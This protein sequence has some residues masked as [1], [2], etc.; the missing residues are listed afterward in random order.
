MK[1]A[2]ADNAGFA[3][4]GLQVHDVAYEDDLFEIDE[5]LLEPFLKQEGF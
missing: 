1:D 3:Y 5:E 2:F 4:V